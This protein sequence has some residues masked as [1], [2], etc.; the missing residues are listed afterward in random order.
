M[1]RSGN[2]VATSSAVSSRLRS[3]MS[4]GPALS[5][6]T[7][8]GV[9]ERADAT[10]V[11]GP[12]FQSDG[13]GEL[14]EISTPG[15]PS[16]KAVGKRSSHSVNSHLNIVGEKTSDANGVASNREHIKRPREI[17]SDRPKRGLQ[18]TKSGEP[19]RKDELSGIPRA[20]S[21]SRA[22]IS[23]RKKNAKVRFEEDGD[24]ESEPALKPPFKESE[25]SDEEYRPSSTNEEQSSGDASV[26]ELFSQRLPAEVLSQS[27]KDLEP[28][29]SSPDRTLR[30]SSCPRPETSI[31]PVS[32][33]KPQLGEHATRSPVESKVGLGRSKHAHNALSKT[34]SSN[35]DGDRKT[36]PTQPERAPRWDPR[37]WMEKY[38]ASFVFDIEGGTGRMWLADGPFEGWI[39]DGPGA[40]SYIPG[41]SAPDEDTLIEAEKVAVPRMVQSWS[42]SEDEASLNG[43]TICEAEVGAGPLTSSIHQGPSTTTNLERL[44]TISKEKSRS[45]VPYRSTSPGTSRKA[46]LLHQAKDK[47]TERAERMNR[48]KQY[49]LAGISGKGI[50][51]QLAT[52]FSTSTS[53]KVSGSLLSTLASAATPKHALTSP[54]AASETTSAL[55][56]RQ[57][58]DDCAPPS[59]QELAE[60]M[61]SSPA[62]RRARG[63][64]PAQNVNGQDGYVDDDVSSSSSEPSSGIPA[65]ISPTKTPPPPPAPPSGRRTPR[66][67]F[68]RSPS[69]AKPRR[70]D[71]GLEQSGA[72]IR[73]RSRVPLKGTPINTNIFVELPALTAEERAEYAVVSPAEEI[74]SA[75]PKSFREINEATEETGVESNDSDA[76][77][78][79]QSPA[80]S[81]LPKGLRKSEP[82]APEPG[83]E[84]PPELQPASSG[85]VATAATTTHTTV[86]KRHTESEKEQRPTS[87]GRVGETRKRD[88]LSSDVSV[89]DP[90][91]VNKKQKTDD[92]QKPSKRLRSHQRRRRRRRELKQRNK[93]NMPQGPK[94]KDTNGLV[95]GNVG[96]Q[97]TVTPT[98]PRPNTPRGQ[99]K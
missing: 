65:R 20:S 55:I 14:G 25:C 44:A 74:D 88:A 61:S 35:E 98:A 92:G 93:D 90:M 22:A 52:D 1:S 15:R 45:P 43:E 18:T 64:S 72:N 89:T 67:L 42:D 19:K 12:S 62:F 97:P 13:D 30:S 81:S 95:E 53:S 2:K 60:L 83:E 5:Q 80:A 31:T 3:T 33:P 78:T 87:E 99:V 86:Q 51:S 94:D 73:S 76:E 16:L 24:V 71:L 91:H 79:L 96:S 58:I 54:S 84:V 69:I 8:S 4:E 10:P 9:R 11:T 39:Y 29:Q 48:T 41:R 85:M 26:D 40:G 68:D 34:S 56:T 38:G 82:A 46:G 70:P 23:S 6:P 17:V 49:V 77:E 66:P 37:S 32:K 63:S 50:N 75:T 59:N 7:Q 36:E 57:L 28:S 47:A 27:A 21:P